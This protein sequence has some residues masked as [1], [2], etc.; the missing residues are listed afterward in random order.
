MSND[1]APEDWDTK[2]LSG[3]AMSRFDVNL[4]ASRLRTMNPTDVAAELT[5]AAQD[6]IDR[7]DLSGL[8]KFLDEEIPQRELAEWAQQKFGL[9]LS[10]EELKDYDLTT[11]GPMILERARETYGK[12]EV[13]Y[14]CE[15]AMEVIMQGAQQDQNWA[16]QQLKGLMKSRYLVELT[17]EE[18][19]AK[20]GQE[21][22]QTIVAEQ[23]A[24]LAK[25]GKLEKEAG[26]L[27][28]KFRHDREALAEKLTERY[29]TVLEDGELDAVPEDQLEDFVYDKG[30]AAFIAEL[31]RLERFVVLQ[32][33]DK[34][35]KDHLY[36]MDQV[37][38]SVGL[39][40]YAEKDPKI[41]YKRE[42]ANQFEEMKRTSRD[43]VTDLI[44]R[45]RL[46][47]NVRLQSAYG[48]NQQATHPGADAAGAPQAPSP[49]MA[50]A[51]AAAVRGGS[52]DQ[53][54]AQQVADRAGSRP[55][56]RSNMTRKQRRAAEARERHEQK[57][58]PKKQ[59]KRK[60]R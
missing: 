16:I 23:E 9:E 8:A 50:A 29:G 25:D 13:T 58:G 32:V 2:G 30:R 10:V 37:K 22:F 52:A 21:I 20:N 57:S 33:L 6:Q 19:K 11:A 36:A 55:D 45:A 39:R 47:P 15:F 54:A 28:A 3:W 44:F 48:E 43:Q 56:P 4:P 34:A 60:S 41:E 27:A 24:W 17:D 1:I 40:G 38:E 53:Q 42:G 59:R 18:I 51:A 46:T 31:T 49:G 26:E 7:K 5:A 14:P 35:W 12:R